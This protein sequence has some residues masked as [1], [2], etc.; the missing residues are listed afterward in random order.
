M[1]VAVTALFFVG[2]AVV[3]LVLGILV[4]LLYFIREAIKSPMGGGW[5]NA[6]R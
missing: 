6:N 3:V 1:E 2:G 5:W 4:A